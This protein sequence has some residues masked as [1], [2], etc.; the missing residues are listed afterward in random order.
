VLP[1]E[2]VKVLTSM[3][4]LLIFSGGHPLSLVYFYFCRVLEDPRMIID[5]SFASRS[6]GLLKRRF[7]DPA[8]GTLAKL[9]S[10]FRL[11]GFRWLANRREH[12]DSLDAF[13]EVNSRIREA[14]VIELKRIKSKTVQVADHCCKR[15]INPHLPLVFDLYLQSCGPG[16]YRLPSF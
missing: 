2:D 12:V 14:M 10:I 8:D 6:I 11:D 1:N 5:N 7:S 16:Q 9:A 15:D 4:P 3:G 13:D